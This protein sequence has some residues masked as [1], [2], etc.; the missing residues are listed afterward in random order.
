MVLVDTMRAE[1]TE[2][3]SQNVQKF[4]EVDPRFQGTVKSL[5]RRHPFQI[6]YDRVLLSNASEQE[7]INNLTVIHNKL[8]TEGTSTK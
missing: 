2:G 5:Q 8:Q 4:R 6:T 3:I 1:F 7:D